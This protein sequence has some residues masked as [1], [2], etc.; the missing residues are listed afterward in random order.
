[1]RRRGL[2]AACVVLLVVGVGVLAIGAGNA[3]D[4]DSG[5]KKCSEATLDGRYLLAQDGVI[6][7]GQN[8]G[9]FALAGYEDF[10]GNGKADV[11]FSANVNG[12]VF[13]NEPATGTYTVEADCTGTTTY[14]ELD[15][16]ADL[17]I[18]PDGS[19][20]TF[21]QVTP[22]TVSSGFDLRGTAKRVGD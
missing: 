1:M 16:Q 5:A 17:F 7:E 15:A 21:V 13:R 4:E 2:W 9:P 6:V 20:F 14:P 11:V 8:K 19:K 22:E 10:H 18:A 3:K 12:E